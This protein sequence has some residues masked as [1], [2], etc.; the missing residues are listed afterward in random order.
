MAVKKK[1][2]DPKSRAQELRVRAA[3]VAHEAGTTVSL[4]VR[5]SLDMYE[6]LVKFAEKSKSPL[7]KVSRWCLSEGLRKYTAFEPKP[8]PFGIVGDIA[9]PSPMNIFDINDNRGPNLGEQS[10]TIKHRNRIESII[11]D[12]DPLKEAAEYSGLSLMGINK[13]PQSK[14]VDQI[15]SY[16]GEDLNS[17]FE[18]QINVE[19]DFDESESDDETS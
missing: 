3:K 12:F 7:A 19:P 6:D 16:A 5:V 11:S 4:N 2:L 14:V 10:P 8:N 17:D 9:S 1:V 13:H 15:T 18:K